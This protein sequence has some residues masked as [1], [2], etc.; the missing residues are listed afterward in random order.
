MSVN[1]KSPVSKNNK[2]K[3]HNHQPP[4]SVVIEHLNSD[5][6]GTLRE[7]SKEVWV[8]GSLPGEKV[9]VAIEHEGQ[10][11]RIGHLLKVQQPSRARIK[12]PCA[13]A[14]RCAGCPIIHM[15]YTEQG[16]FKNELI[17]RALS[18]YPNLS[19]L[20]PGEIW[21]AT[22]PLGYRT[23]AKLALAKVGGKAL[24]GL[25]QRGSHRVIDLS[26]CPQHHPLIN[27]IA[28]ALREEIEKQDLH[29]YNPI[30]RRGLLRYLAV[31]VSP[32]YN[33]AL[34]TLVCSERNYRE[35][36]HLAKWLKKKVPEIVGVHQNVNASSGNVIFGPNTF[37]ILGA[38]DLIDQ[39]GDVRL[40]LSP[41][42]FFQVN[43]EQAARI[44][45]QVTRWADLKPGM[46][47][48]DIYCGIGGIALHLAASG[49]HVTG[50]EINPEAIHNARAAAQMNKLSHCSFITGDA[51]EVMEDLRLDLGS[52]DVA[53]INPPR[54]GCSEDVLGSL[55]A[56]KP[57]TL[58]YVSCNPHSLARD[59]DYLIRHGYQPCELQPVDMFPQ[60][61]HVE[62]LVRLCPKNVDKPNTN[63]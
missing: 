45:H 60:T 4:R 38:D 32:T 42:S 44:Y 46:T 51:S 39:I 57:S 61:P 16:H 33:K 62:S 48:L 59:L 14:P 43:H 6:V 49:A 58:I 22:K 10:H 47:A 9:L 23:T 36:T 13:L 19:S 50:V 3:P 28:Q 7:D 20:Q 40:R 30:N 37:K 2:K 25:Y 5:G 53:V 56:L 17:Q 18:L 41:S 15:N 12:P 35:M 54:S 52:V 31:R 34:V 63:A 21:S 1:K 29:V 8:A 24:V 11:R 55:V 27:R 26:D